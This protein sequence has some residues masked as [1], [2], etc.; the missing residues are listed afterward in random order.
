[1][2]PKNHAELA[3][4]HPDAKLPTPAECQQ[5]ARELTARV[6][7]LAHTH[8]EGMRGAAIQTLA[9]PAPEP[10]KGSAALGIAAKAAEG[11]TAAHAARWRKKHRQAKAAVALKNAVAHLE[12]HGTPDS[13]P[14]DLLWRVAALHAAWDIATQLPTEDAGHLIEATH[15]SLVTALQRRAALQLAEAKKAGFITRARAALAAWE[16]QEHVADELE[17]VAELQ[18]AANELE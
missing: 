10:V 9:P 17:K 8:P 11:F 16:T 13:A 1:M 6:R 15:V 2:H 12:R 4:A 14:Q 7:K 3:H 5:L 18:A